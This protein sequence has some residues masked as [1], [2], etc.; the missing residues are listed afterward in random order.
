[1]PRVDF[2]REVRASEGTQIG[3]GIDDGR[4]V[5]QFDKHVR[6]VAFEPQHALDLVEKICAM[7]AQLGV[8]AIPDV[9]KDKQ[10]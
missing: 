9:P 10:H 2:D 5:M 7:C 8:V 4:V 3:F 6:C 1:M